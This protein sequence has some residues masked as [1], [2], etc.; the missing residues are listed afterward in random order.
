MTP[1]RMTTVELEQYLPDTGCDA[2]GPSCLACPLPDCQY[3]G[4]PAASNQAVRNAAIGERYYA[5]R[6]PGVPVIVL[7]AAEFGVSH[8]TVARAVS[9]AKQRAQEVAL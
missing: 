5:L 4:Q 6:G 8:R 1:N 3:D 9:R 2:G 7:L